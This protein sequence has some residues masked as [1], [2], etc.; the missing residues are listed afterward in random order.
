[1]LVLMLAV[2]VVGEVGVGSNVEGDGGDVVVADVG[3]L[4]L[5]SL[6]SLPLSLLCI[7]VYVVSVMGG[8]VGDVGGCVDVAFDGGSSVAIVAVV[9]VGVTLLLVVVVSLRLL[10]LFVHCYRCCWCGL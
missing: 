2:V 3:C 7:V 4:L 1:M 8:G 9:S 6:S 10:L 5:L